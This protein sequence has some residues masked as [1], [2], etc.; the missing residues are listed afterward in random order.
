MFARRRRHPLRRIDR[1]DAGRSLVNWKN[2]FA[3]GVAIHFALALRGTMISA[4]LLAS[5]PD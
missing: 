4:G 1:G 2:N 5:A 3:S